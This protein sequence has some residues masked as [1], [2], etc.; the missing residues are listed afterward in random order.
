MQQPPATTLPDATIPFRRDPY[1]YARRTADA[2]GT[3]VFR[4]RL[5]LRPAVFFRGAEAAELLYDEQKFTR[6]DAVPGRIGSV[7]FGKGGV[8]GLDG[9]AHRARK[10]MLMSL[11]TPQRMEA[12]AGRVRE[13]LTERL[14]RADDLCVGEVARD[15][16][17]EAVLH[18][19]GLGD[20]TGE[21]AEKKGREMSR[22]FGHAADAGP[23]HLRARQTRR[24][25]DAWAAE[26][27]TA[28]RE[29]RAAAPEGSA[30]AVTAAW[31]G[32]DGEVL[33]PEVAG[34][35]LL[36]VL[37]P[38]VAVAL[39]V[40]FL[41]HALA[42]TGAR[43]ATEGERRTFALEV[44]R[45]YPFFP[46]LGAR[47][48]GPVS[49]GGMEL[50]GDSRVLLDVPGTNTHPGTWRDPD[51]FDPSRFE[52]A[53]PGPFDMVPQGGGDFGTG[54]RC[55]GEWLTERLMLA[56]LEVFADRVAWTAGTQDLDLTHAAVPPRV[57]G[58]MRIRVLGAAA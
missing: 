13:G 31:R 25:L 39:W 37:R 54:H 35:E 17:A 5:M 44:R 23:V 11:M 28:L 4:T 24:R 6:A 22:L 38:M 27:V 3:D 51:R 55:A 58:G 21:A 57:R 42:V 40:E 50:P 56:A 9:D 41:V 34:V 49:V 48:R 19:A 43:P 46:V 45:L 47:T 15:A 16:I 7:L 20:L 10:A 32:P 29:G 8:Q 52:G 1:G 53:E 36:N 18:W 26:R 30:L 14:A 33:V 2:L 12:L